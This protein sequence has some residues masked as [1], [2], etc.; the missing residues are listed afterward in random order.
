MPRARAAGAAAAGCKRAVGWGWM[1]YA[2]VSERAKRAC[3][4]LDSG[5]KAQ[6]PAGMACRA[7]RQKRE[8]DKPSKGKDSRTKNEEVHSFVLPCSR[9]L[10]SIRSD[11]SHNRSSMPTFALSTLRNLS[12]CVWL[13]S[14]VGLSLE[15]ISAS[16]THRQSITPSRDCHPV[17]P[18]GR[19]LPVVCDRAARSFR[20]RA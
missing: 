9:V 6:Q 17:V 3:V 4:M 16:L 1:R 14:G 20:S 8:A 18:V 15:L 19:R 13:G 2:W 10:R 7:D 5:S 12:V 11:P